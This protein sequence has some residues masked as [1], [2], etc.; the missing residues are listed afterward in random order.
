MYAYIIYINVCMHT[1]YIHKCKYIYTYAHRHIY[2]CM[3]TAEVS[4][5]N[6][7]HRQTQQ[8]KD[9]KVPKYSSSAKRGK[10]THVNVHIHVYTP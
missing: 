8:H 2:I 9:S 6:K 1:S 5:G 4:L 3:Y 10:H 7:K